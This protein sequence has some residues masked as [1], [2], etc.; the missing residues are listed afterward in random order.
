MQKDSRQIASRS[1]LLELVEILGIYAGLDSAETKQKLLIKP[2][3]ACR[4]YIHR[5]LLEA[6][7]RLYLRANQQ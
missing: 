5:S 1:E 6:E 7:Q 3:R 4:Q 2:V